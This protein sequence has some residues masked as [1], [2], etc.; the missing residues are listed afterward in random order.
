MTLQFLSKCQQVF[1]HGTTVLQFLEMV[2]FLGFSAED[3]FNRQKDVILS[4]EDK[5]IKCWS[6]ILMRLSGKIETPDISNDNVKNLFNKSPQEKDSTKVSVIYELFLSIVKCF[7]TSILPSGQIP[8]AR[9]HL[10]AT[11]DM[12]LLKLYFADDL[13]M[14]MAFKGEDS[15]DKKIVFNRITDVQPMLKNISDFLAYEDEDVLSMFYRAQSL[16]VPR[17]DAIVYTAIGKPGI[18]ADTHA[19]SFATCNDVGVLCK[20]GKLNLKIYASDVFVFNFNPQTFGEF[21]NFKKC[22]LCDLE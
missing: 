15:P 3:E 9:H 4:K 22:N 13:K 8:Y 12:P 1:Q 5:I 2:L 21:L 11:S 14:F 10:T 7:D 20:T 19:Y 6:E 16:S 17:A 18:A